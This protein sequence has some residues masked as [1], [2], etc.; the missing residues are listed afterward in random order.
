MQALDADAEARQKTGRRQRVADDEE[1][2][3]QAMR[4]ARPQAAGRRQSGL[5]ELDQ[6]AEVRPGQPVSVTVRFAL[7]EKLG[8][9]QI[10]VTFKQGKR[11][12]RVDRKIITV[13]GAG[14][15]KIEF[16][17]P[18]SIEDGL[19]SFAA[20]VGEDFQTSLQHVTTQP[21]RVK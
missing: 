21:Q 8:E 10:Q 18:A 7:P 17:A 13:S 9:Q 1:E 20:F 5:L 12:T 3:R 15:R 16:A 19:V 2:A 14:E 11:G 6:P 4:A